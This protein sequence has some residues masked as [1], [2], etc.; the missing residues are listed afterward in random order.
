M[1]RRIKEAREKVMEYE[2]HRI[3][4]WE[5]E[6]GPMLNSASTDSQCKGW[7]VYCYETLDSTMAKA[8]EKVGEISS[9]Q[10]L[11]ILARGQTQGRGRHGRRWLSAV[12]GFYGT[13]CFATKKPP[14]D[15]ISFP[16]VAGVAVAELL[17]DLGC[18]IKLKWPNDVL[19]Q[20]KEKLS[21][22]LVELNSL[23]GINYIL[24]GIGINLKGV[25][26]GVN[27]SD[28]FSLTGRTYTP[29]HI[30]IRLG[31]A[32]GKMAEEFFRSGF[33]PFKDRWLQRATVGSPTTVHVGN[34]IIPGTFCGITDE[35]HLLL[36]TEDGLITITSG[37]VFHR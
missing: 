13:F 29:P 28:L 30:A 35:G 10:N 17:E 12:E 18:G 9:D 8:S 36:D 11:L 24:C 33:T 14:E 27:A 21:G 31:S 7:K 37:E 5:N 22:I 2:S 23:S 32:L 6:I 19:T 4:V 34:N 16:L 3:I 25:P 20:D 26:K 15:I 1:N